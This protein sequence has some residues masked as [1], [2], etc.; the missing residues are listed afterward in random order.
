MTE[1]LTLGVSKKVI[2]DKIGLFTSYLAG[3]R[4]ENYVDYD[5][6]AVHDLDIRILDYM[7]EDAASQLAANLGSAIAN[8]DVDGDIMRFV[9][10]NPDSP[11][12]N[13]GVLLTLIES[14]IMSQTVTGWLRI[15]GY[16]FGEGTHQAITSATEV[17]S[18][19]LKLIQAAL[20]PAKQAAS[21]SGPQILKARSRRPSPI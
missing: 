12:F 5:R 7:A 2:F 20:N 18:S 21:A 6:I 3:K 4:T 1:F 8:F 13:S 16:E 11:D 9:V 19:K 15:V 17:A 10:R 14:Y